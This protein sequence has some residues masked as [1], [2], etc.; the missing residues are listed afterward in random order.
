MTPAPTSAACWNGS[1]S[2]PGTSS[3]AIAGSP[4]TGVDDAI[5]AARSLLARGPSLVCLSIGAGGNVLVWDGGYA[6]FPL[7]E[8]RAPDPVAADDAFTAALA[9]ALMRG[10]SYRQA[11]RAATQ[12]ASAAGHL[13]DALR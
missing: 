12:A 6:V 13:T 2:T 10:E 3:A 8:T 11:G 1:R 5:A 4:L 7:E 9:M